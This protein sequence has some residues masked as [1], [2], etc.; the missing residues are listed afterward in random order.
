MNIPHSSWITGPLFLKVL[1]HVKEHAR[2]SKEDSVILLMDSH[3]SHCILDSTLYA[4]ESGI[5][6][7]T[8]PLHCS[9]R[10]QP[11]DVGVMGPFKGKLRQAQHDWII[12]NP[13]EVVT[14]HDLTSLTNGAY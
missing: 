5:T 7:V 8:F 13:C 11:L 14:V 10:L 2:S 9:H 3:E 1:E 12:A 4:R 6:L